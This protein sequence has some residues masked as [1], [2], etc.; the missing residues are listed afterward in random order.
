VLLDYIDDAVVKH[1]TTELP[2][3]GIPS[4][5]VAKSTS[6]AYSCERVPAVIKPPVRERHA[7]GRTR[8]VRASR[9]I[10]M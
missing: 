1:G 6:Y 5:T 7:T 3:T 2:A 4:K 10:E 9:M 8:R